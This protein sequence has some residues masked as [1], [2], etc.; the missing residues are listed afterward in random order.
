MNRLRTRT[1][2]LAVLALA[3]GGAWA[4]CGGGGG[5]SRRPAAG[6]GKPAFKKAELPPAV[7]VKTFESNIFEQGAQ[8]LELEE[9]QIA[10]IREDRDALRKEGQ[11]LE[12]GQNAA[13]TEY[14]A[15]QDAAAAT[16]AA[17]KVKAAAKK[18]EDFDPEKKWDG[19]LKKEL[20]AEQYKK[21]KE[22]EARVKK[23]MQGE[24]GAGGPGGQ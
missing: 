14:N 15:A 6:S 10:K 22:Y 9:A 13:R 3:A 21:W 18:A 16:A 24:G 17:A 8:F 11:E 19:I 7:Q 4:G 1:A 5:G 12:Q 23:E 2:L 20:K